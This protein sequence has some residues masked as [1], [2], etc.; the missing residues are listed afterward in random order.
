MNT[1]T[2]YKTPNIAYYLYDDSDIVHTNPLLP[3]FKVSELPF[4]D[5]E[6]IYQFRRNRENPIRNVMASFQCPMQCSYCYNKQFKN[7]GYSVRLRPVENVIEEC[8]ELIKNYPTQ[9]IYFQDDIFPVY[10]LDWLSAFCEQYKKRVKTP[11]HIQVRIEMVNHECVQW[12]K[13]AGLHGVTYAIETADETARRDL[14]GR[15]VN[16]NVILAGAK[17]LQNHGIKFRIENMLGIPGETFESA[18][19]TLDLNIKCQP[20]VA[21]AS[22]FAPYPGTDLGDYCQKE[23]L[24]LGDFDMDF[25]THATLKLK[26]KKQIERLQKLF[27]LI[28]TVPLFRPLVPALTALPFK[29]QWIYKWVK[30][31][32]YEKTLYKVN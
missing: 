5:R 18:L 13:S 19:R 25:F 4:P 29:Y 16:D 30:N 15:V 1:E 32:L 24:I 12:L 2:I 21:W 28:C 22:L 27:G 17:L 23:N 8:G 10:R 14:L 26:D 20:D 6:L 3:A 9:L 11:F 7:M 31:W